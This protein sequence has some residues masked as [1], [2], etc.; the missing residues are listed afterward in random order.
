MQNRNAR[1]LWSSINTTLIISLSY[2]VRQWRILSVKKSAVKITALFPIIL[3]FYCFYFYSFLFFRN[4]SKTIMPYKSPQKHLMLAKVPD[5]PVKPKIGV[6]SAIILNLILQNYR[7]L[8]KQRCLLRHQLLQ[9]PF[10]VRNPLL[11]NADKQLWTEYRNKD[12][13]SAKIHIFIGSVLIEL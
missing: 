5:Q 10:S 12:K 9:W 11:N 2:V 13:Q 3:L 8:S 4:G 1:S 6:P 7:R